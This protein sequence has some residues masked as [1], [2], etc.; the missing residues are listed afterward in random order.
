MSGK[1]YSDMERK[2]LISLTFTVAVHSTHMYV[3]IMICK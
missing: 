1:H 2:N 3:Y